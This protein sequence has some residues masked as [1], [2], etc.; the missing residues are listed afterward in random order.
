MVRRDARELVAEMTDA[1]P[2]RQREPVARVALALAEQ[3]RVD[4]H[5]ERLVPHPLRPLDEPTRDVA[6]A[7]DVELEP[8]RAAA[9]NRGDVFEARRGQRAQHLGHAGMRGGAGHSDLAVG[10]GEP[11]KRRRGQQDRPVV[12]PAEDAN[13]WTVRGFL[14]TAPDE[15][16]SD[17]LNDAR[18]FVPFLDAGGPMRFLA[19]RHIVEIKPIH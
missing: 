14:F 11:R 18:E 8:E 12:V 15:R 1:E 9:G 19:K 16:I 2:G 3:R 7:E 13:G 10:M 6:I 5:H 4:R 17:L